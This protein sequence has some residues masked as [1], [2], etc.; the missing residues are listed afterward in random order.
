MIQKLVFVHT[1]LLPQSFVDAG[2]PVIKFE[3][4]HSSAIKALRLCM[5]SYNVKKP[6]V[7]ERMIWDKVA[8]SHT[9]AGSL[10]YQNLLERRSGLQQRARNLDDGLAEEDPLVC[11]VLLEEREN[12]M[13]ITRTVEQE[14]VLLGRPASLVLNFAEIEHS[15]EPSPVVLQRPAAIHRQP[16]TSP[17][18]RVVGEWAFKVRQFWRMLMTDQ[19]QKTRS[20]IPKD[21]GIIGNEVING[22]KA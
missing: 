4:D 10:L 8:M 5:N 2:T 13:A 21:R 15:E 14:L 1:E 22:Q 19:R 18:S 12:V 9:T 3:N 17:R 11:Q 7:L 20:T 16:I 6:F